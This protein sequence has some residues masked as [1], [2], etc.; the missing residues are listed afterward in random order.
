MRNRETEY[1]ANVAFTN[2]PANVKV[3]RNFAK[4]IPRLVA[5]K[6]QQT[7][8]QKLLAKSVK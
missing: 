4:P 7:F 3:G 6:P 1:T 8:M 2:A 5:Q